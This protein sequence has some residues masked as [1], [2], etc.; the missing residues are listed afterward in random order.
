M[1]EKN[2]EYINN[3]ALKRRLSKIS[4]TEARSNISY[5]MSESNDYVL[6]KDD[7]PSDDLVNP[8]E[9]I[10]KMLATNITHEMQSND[11]I[12]TFG[13]GLGYLLDETFSKYPS[14]IYVYEPDINLLTFALNNVDISD[15]LASGRVYITNDLDELIA[16]LSDSFIT[17]DKVEIV[18]LQNYAVVKNKELLMLTQKVYETCKS[19]MIDINTISKFSDVWLKNTIRNITLINNG[20]FYK[21]SDLYN[22]YA[23]QT[24][25]VIGAGPSL[26]DNLKNIQ[27]NRNKFVIIAVNKIVKYLIQNGV[28]PDFVTCLDARN[29]DTTLGGLDLSRISGIVDIRTDSSVF[30]KNFKKIFVN[31]SESDTIS[32]KISQYNDSMQFMESGGSASTFALAAA[33]QMGFSK[34]VLVGVD[35]AFK[36]SVA[37][38]NGDTI[39][40]ISQDEILADG[41][42]KNLVQVRSVTGGMI[43]TRDDY[44]SFIHHFV[45]LIKDLECKEIYNVSSFGANIEGA[46][47]K[48]FS[49]LYLIIP[50]A[51]ISLNNLTPFKLNIKIFIDEEFCNIN[52]IISI[53]S[54]GVFSPALVSSI[55]KS[56]LI[57]QYMQ[58]EIVAVLQRNFD[59]QLADEFISKTKTA[60]KTTVELLQENKLV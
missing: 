25:L 17:K 60:I 24:A 44:E 10:K 19:K 8:R 29:M 35:L 43:Y 14:R 40:R 38:A 13:F 46:V 6:L 9:A 58:T 57:Y 23:G 1:F 41:I 56:V 50:A 2:L 54:K 4:M 33:S 28:T 42:K 52:N 34:V 5:C 31:F 36:D 47:N 27:E 48:S 49:D 15:H 12:I 26:Q 51:T 11:I 53:L 7:I 30:S 59:A 45:S 18:Y 55:V 20:E 32:Q 21:L 37:Y 39:N 16:K 3:P 22:K